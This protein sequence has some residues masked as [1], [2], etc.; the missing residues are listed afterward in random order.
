[1]NNIKKF[2]VLALILISSAVTAR[3]PINQWADLPQMKKMSCDLLG[4]EESET[5]NE[6]DW[7]SILHD[8][9]YEKVS[10]EFPDKTYVLRHHGMANYLC[11]PDNAQYEMLTIDKGQPGIKDFKEELFGEFVNYITKPE[12]PGLIS[13]EKVTTGSIG[14]IDYKEVIAVHINGGYCKGRIYVTNYSFYIVL[15]MYDIYAKEIDYD[16]FIKS[17]SVN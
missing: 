6:S 4:M 11:F 13:I 16:R 1:M 7:V 15:M 9:G 12:L 2:F 17:F 10:L 5:K 14:E 8:N 3:E